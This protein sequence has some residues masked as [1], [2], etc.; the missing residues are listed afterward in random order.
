MATERLTVATNQSQIQT[1]DDPS[2]ETKGARTRA[3]IKQVIIDLVGNSSPLEVTLGDICEGA[4]V[5]VGSFY[6]H[7]K[8][9]D[10][11]LEETAIDVIRDYYASISSVLGRGGSIDDQLEQ[12]MHAF[13]EDY[14]NQP[15]RTRLIRMVIPGNTAA[16][17]VWEE[18]RRILSQGL[19]TMISDARGSQ[20]GHEILSFFTSEFLL[21]ATE[22][23]LEHLFFGTD[24][25]LQLAVGSPDLV[26]KNIAAI[27]ERAILNDNRIG[28][29]L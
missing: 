12:L 5:T 3:L 24:Q 25:R 22:S 15:T 29:Y 4:N 19:E 28:D 23:F 21:T 8:N 14:A 2:K 9:K 18:E 27:W 16:L 7:F 10:A 26:I 17:Q 11:A 6:F 1:V 20:G 13:V